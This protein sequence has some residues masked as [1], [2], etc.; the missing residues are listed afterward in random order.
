MGHRLVP[1]TES[2]KVCWW[3][4]LPEE[5]HQSQT[6]LDLFSFVNK[7]LPL[8]SKKLIYNTYY[9]ITIHV[10]A[11]FFLWNRLSDLEFDICTIF[12][13][14]MLWSVLEHSASHLNFHEGSSIRLLIKYF[15]FSSPG[16]QNEVGWVHPGELQHQGQHVLH[17]WHPCQADP[18]VQETAAQLLPHHHALQPPQAWPKPGLCSQDYHGRRKGKVVSR[19]I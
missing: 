3:W 10:I 1:T 13:L 2:Q 17:L 12:Y 16:K 15:L 14:W 8:K 18:R 11:Y 7:T 5:H 19:Y 9:E 6:G 4:K